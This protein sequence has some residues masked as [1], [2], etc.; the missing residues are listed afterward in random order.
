MPA[1]I[2]TSGKVARIVLSGAFDFSSQDELKRVFD[3]GIQAATPQIRIDM[4]HTTFIDSGVIRLILKFH[5]SAR[6][7]KKSLAI[8]NC[9]ERIYE[10]FAVG[11]FDQI[12]DI[13]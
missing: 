6:K 1:T 5:D 11:G 8:I 9:N 7:N 10:I 13:H 3:E 2:S 4:Q 12:F